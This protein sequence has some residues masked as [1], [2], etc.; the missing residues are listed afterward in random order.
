MWGPALSLAHQR[1]RRARGTDITSRAQIT[2]WWSGEHQQIEQ[3]NRRYRV[4][5]RRSDGLHRGGGRLARSRH[6]IHKDE[7]KPAITD[8][9]SRCSVISETFETHNGR[10]ADCC[11]RAPLERH[12]GNRQGLLCASSARSREPDVAPGV[13]AEC[14]Q[15]ARSGFWGDSQKSRPDS[16]HFGSA[17]IRA[18]ATSEVVAFPPRSGV[19]GAS[20]DARIV[21]MAVTTSRAASS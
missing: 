4:R 2:A 21:S 20:L 6:R 17:T 10:C 19:L 18:L 8:R 7:P 13:A 16:A 14:L 11:R 3:R 9:A 1:E 15:A 5:H 12:L